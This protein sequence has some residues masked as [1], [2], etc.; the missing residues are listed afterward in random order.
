MKLYSIKITKNII[1]FVYLSLMLALPSVYANPCADIDLDD[2]TIDLED[3]FR[4]VKTMLDLATAINSDKDSKTAAAR[5]YARDFAALEREVAKLGTDTKKQIQGCVE[6]LKVGALLVAEVN[7]QLKTKEFDSSFDAFSTSD[8]GKLA[9]KFSQHADAAKVVKDLGNVDKDVENKAIVKEQ[10]TFTTTL[11]K[12]QD[13]IDKQ[14]KNVENFDIDIKGVQAK[15]TA[16]KAALDKVKA[17]YTETDLAK[18]KADVD[19]SVITDPSAIGVINTAFDRVEEIKKLEGDK[20]KEAQD[21][22]ANEKNLPKEEIDAQKLAKS[23]IA[24]IKTNFENV[25]KNKKAELALEPAELTALLKDIKDEADGCS[26]STVSAFDN[27]S[28]QLD[29]CRES[30][31]SIVQS[32][33]DAVSGEDYK[34]LRVAGSDDFDVKAFLAESKDKTKMCIKF[35]VHSKDVARA[36][37]SKKMDGDAQNEFLSREEDIEIGDVK[38]QSINQSLAG[39]CYKISKADVKNT[40]KLHE[41]V[42]KAFDDQVRLKDGNSSALA[43]ILKEAK[44]DLGSESSVGSA[45]EGLDSLNDDIAKLKDNHKIG[46][47]KKLATYLADNNNEDETRCESLRAAAEHLGIELDAEATR[48]CMTKEER[49]AKSKVADKGEE[50]DKEINP[51]QAVTVGQL[52]DILNEQNEIYQKNFNDFQS[53]IA[54]CMGNVMNQ[55]AMASQM[56]IANSINQVQN[57]FTKSGVLRSA[58]IGRALAQGMNGDSNFMANYSTNAPSSGQIQQIAEDFMNENARSEGKIRAELADLDSY[59]S[60]LLNIVNNVSFDPN[61]FS[62]MN[63]DRANASAL[64]GTVE[65][66]A[67]AIRERS[68]MNATGLAGVPFGGNAITT[69]TTSSAFNTGATNVRATSTGVNRAPSVAPTTRTTGGPTSGPAPF[70]TNNPVLRR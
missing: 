18:L 3:K 44:S 16:D 49:E 32:R 26:E 69:N 19:G 58:I 67:D 1:K 20:K 39:E 68:R 57:A 70:T 22:A 52:K 53:T 2:T 25:V 30:L 9:G 56:Q 47:L 42:K 41:A 63:I 33:A 60:K 6:H 50:E 21:L 61:P 38:I 45:I 46:D 13:Q 29:L 62:Q 23:K 35:R 7:K 34:E 11:T 24:A 36:A 65:S 59:R 8:A 28:T 4:E 15:I 40:T 12:K 14:K 31:L 66:A 37:I 48:T 55:R 43:S 51:N 54:R 64:L 10:D 17:D 5:K 27:V